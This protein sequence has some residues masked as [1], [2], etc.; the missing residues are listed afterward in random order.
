MLKHLLTGLTIPQQY[1]CTGFEDFRS[2]FLVYAT[3]RK[4]N[5]RLDVSKTNILL[6]YKPLIMLLPDVPPEHEEICLT[7]VRKDFQ[8][9]TIW[10][11]FETDASAVARL[12]LKAKCKISGTG[13]AALYEGLYGE[14]N[15]LSPLHQF[16]NNYRERL[17]KQKAGNIS[18][19][20]N[21]QDQVRIAYSTPRI[22]ALITLVLNG[23][24]NMFPTDLHGDWGK[25]FYVSSLRHGGRANEQV[26]Q[27]GVVA[28]S[29][30]PVQEFSF[31]YSLGKN[32]MQKTDFEDN[33]RL[34]SI[35][36]S[37]FSIPL[38]ESTLGY[39]ELKRLYSVDLGLHRIHVY[40]KVHHE[41][42][43]PGSTL[44]HIHQYSAQW[45]AD[46]GLITQIFLR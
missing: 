43:H 18:L 8:P 35:T 38:P 32:H 2:P 46:H 31:A 10:N 14:H 1:I 4:K 23:R 40:K 34:H 7:F 22:I 45:R 25:D 11:G 20:G 15:F 33:F 9:N 16:V 6:G 19:P 21:L 37:V 17:R 5:L 44:A 29:F 26:E 41:I 27:S 24:M 39:L 12:I 30:I 42:L 36:S 13:E 28:L 3:S